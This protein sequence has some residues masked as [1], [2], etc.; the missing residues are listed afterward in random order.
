MRTAAEYRKHAHALARAFRV[1]LR[2]EHGRN[3]SDAG[4]GIHAFLGKFAVCA[5][6]IDET[7]YIVAL[8]EL[9]HLIDPMGHLLEQKSKRFQQHHVYCDARD[10]RLTIDEEVAAWSWAKRHAIEWTPA[11]AS[12]RR[13][14]FGSYLALAKQARIKL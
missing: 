3:P 12:V 14:T 2:E 8:H 10:V 4:A 1:I 11:M 5:P 7:T 13:M 9:G 6:I